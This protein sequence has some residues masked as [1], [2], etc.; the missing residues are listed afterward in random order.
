L[1][2][3]NVVRVSPGASIH[4]APNMTKTGV[5][6]RKQAMTPVRGTMG[7]QPTPTPMMLAT[8]TVAVNAEDQ[9]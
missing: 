2:F 5:M 1:A 7:I 3:S 4:D 6:N 8:A 9:A